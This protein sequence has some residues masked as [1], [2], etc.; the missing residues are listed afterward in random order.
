MVFVNSMS[1]L[2][3]EQ[4][5]DDYIVAVCRVM[6]MADWHTFQILS[7]RSQRMRDLLA[8]RL[9][10]A[11]EQP[12]L[13]WGVSVEDRQHGFPRVE[14]LRETP[15]RVRFSSI[16]PL[17]E[18]LGGIP[19]GGIN[20]VIV[21]GESGPGA[22]PMEEDWVRSILRQC[23]EAEIPFFFKQWGGVFKKRAGRQLDGRTYD[24]W[25]EIVRRPVPSFGERRAWAREIERLAQAR[26]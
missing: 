10:F 14:H 2:F 21:G 15:V 12:H 20:W 7:K 13:W 4:I 6:C 23:R 17:L 3:H 18:D 25:P 22:R 8:T 1:D 26:T 24:E 19:L 11:A 16:E 9:K 5:P